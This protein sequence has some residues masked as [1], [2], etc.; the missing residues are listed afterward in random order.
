M[1]IS[2][3]SLHHRNYTEGGATSTGYKREKKRSQIR[4]AE[5]ERGDYRCQE[6]VDERNLLNRA[7]WG[8]EVGKD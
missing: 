1:S 5:E 3:V 2:L 7:I 8:G 4:N 6:A